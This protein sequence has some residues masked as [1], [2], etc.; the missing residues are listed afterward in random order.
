MRYAFLSLFLLCGMAIQAQPRFKGKAAMDTAAKLIASDSVAIALQHQKDSI[1][2][3]M[4]TDSE[5]KAAMNRNGQAI[6]E[7]QQNNTARQ[8]KS[9]I[10]NIAIG[11]GFFALLIFGL[12]RRRK[13]PGNS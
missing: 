2:E 4:R 5:A 6:L 8:R 1:A 9:A 11:L 13:K 3:R 7:L 10:K 12:L